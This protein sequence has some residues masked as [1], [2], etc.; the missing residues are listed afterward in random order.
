MVLESLGNQIIE[1]ALELGAS[2]AGIAN[3]EELKA[4]PSHCISGK[5][6]EFGGVGVKKVEGRKQGEVIWPDKAGSA[7]V[8]ALEHP[9]EIPDMDF[10]VKG[11]K[12]VPPEGL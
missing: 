7:V 6:A 5:V 10:W 2:L 8:I 1:K 9:K 11:Q 12:G 3:I 4:S